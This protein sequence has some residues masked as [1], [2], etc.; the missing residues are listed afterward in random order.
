MVPAYSG[1]SVSISHSCYTGS[2]HSK[3]SIVE[4][5]VAIVCDHYEHL[6]SGHLFINDGREM[7]LL[8]Q[9]YEVSQYCMLLV[10]RVLITILSLPL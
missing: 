7:S 4:L 8:K 5:S 2:L 6:Y 1:K 10:L 3:Q 9:K